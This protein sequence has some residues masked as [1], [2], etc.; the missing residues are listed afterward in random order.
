MARIKDMEDQLAQRFAAQAGAGWVEDQFQHQGYTVRVA[1]GLNRAGQ[2]SYRYW[3]GAHRL[4]RPVLQALLCTQTLC[5]QQQKLQQRW[6]AF[7]GK[8]R[9]QRREE[10]ALFVHRLAEE[11]SLQGPGGT[12]WTARQAKLRVNV[13]C[14][15]AAHP[16][17]RVQVSAWDLFNPSGYVAGGLVQEPA[18]GAASGGGTT[19]RPLFLTL[20]DVTQWI[21]QTEAACF[22]SSI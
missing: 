6:S 15:E 17:Q 2:P 12:V 4:E 14:P 3:V 10:P 9:P 21:A 5:L 22:Q 1:H 7:T 8:A 18:G 13:V 20:E 11:V 19:Q 16:P